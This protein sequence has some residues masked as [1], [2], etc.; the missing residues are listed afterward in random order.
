[1]MV[2][3]TRTT[4]TGVAATAPASSAPTGWVS[5]WPATCTAGSRPWL[6]AT[7]WS[8]TRAR[9]PASIREYLRSGRPSASTCSASS[10]RA[11]STVVS[12]APP[13]GPN[14][15]TCRVNASTSDRHDAPVTRAATASVNNRPRSRRGQNPRRAT[16]PRRPA[17]SPTRSA[18]RRGRTTPACATTP[19]PPE[20]SSNRAD[21]P[22]AGSGNADS[23]AGRVPVRCTIRVLRSLGDYKPLQLVFSQ[24][25]APSPVPTGRPGPT[26]V[27][28]PG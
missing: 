12:E 14:S 25:G 27:N 11:R 9:T 23:P 1:M 10:S 6:P 16:T 13:A 22:A 20:A 5:G 7:I 26:R 2:A 8:H 19:R 3:S 21:Q 15:S 18:S 4:V 24:V 17:V 28:T